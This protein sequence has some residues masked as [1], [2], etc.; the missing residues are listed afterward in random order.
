M[1]LPVSHFF[2]EVQ[3]N[4]LFLPERRAGLGASQIGRKTAQSLLLPEGLR[5]REFAQARGFGDPDLT[6]A[7]T[8]AERSELSKCP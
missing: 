5:S 8:D 2:D 4:V 1:S 3:S 6:P 7:T